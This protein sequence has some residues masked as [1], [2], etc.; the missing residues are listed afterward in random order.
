M[1]PSRKINFLH[2]RSAEGR[3]AIHADGQAGRLGGQLVVAGH[4][5][6]QAAHLMH[7]WHHDAP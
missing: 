7:T 3:E 6:N 1:L 2:Q 4:K 5:V